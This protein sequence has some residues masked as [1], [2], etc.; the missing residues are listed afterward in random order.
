[1]GVHEARGRVSYALWIRYFSEEE[2]WRANIRYSGYVRY[3][4][5]LLQIGDF[6]SY[7]DERIQ[8]HVPVVSAD[9]YVPYL[10]L[11]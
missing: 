1:M 10:T 3:L 2:W 7:E 9:W 8:D 4:L 11:P 5:W 6:S